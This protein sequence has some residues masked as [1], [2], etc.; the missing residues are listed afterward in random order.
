MGELFRS[1]GL[2]V[3]SQAHVS[4]AVFQIISDIL[5]VVSV[6]LCCFFFNFVKFCKNVQ[7]YEFMIVKN[8]KLE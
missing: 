6:I 3:R 2:P 5:N 1:L 8:V 7:H 4:I